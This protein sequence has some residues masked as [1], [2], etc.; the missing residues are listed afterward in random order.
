MAHITVLHLIHHFATAGIGRLVGVW[1]E[2]LEERNLSLH[3]GALSGQ[4]DLK[5]EFRHLGVQVVDFSEN[6]NRSSN[7]IEMVRDYVIANQ[8]SIVHSHSPRTR[9]AAAAALAGL[10]Q[11]AH[12]ATEHLF[13]SPWDRRWGL[14]YALM[15]WFSLYLPDHIVTVS[16]HMRD[17][18]VALPGLSSKRVTAVQNS[19]D[20]EV[21]YMPDERDACRLEFKLAP[22]SKVVGYTGRLEKQ[23]RLDLLLEGFSTVLVQHPQARL[24]IVGDGWLR[25]KLEDLAADLGIS[26]A[27][28]WT[29][30][31]Q[32]I[33]RLLSAMDI[34]IL[35][36]A[37]E[38]LSMS[39]LE[40]MAAG[41]PSIVTDV[42]GA[43]EVVAS[44]S[45]GILIPPGSAS[46]IATA[47]VDLIDHPEKLTALAKAG[48]SR[49]FEDFSVQR[50]AE[51]YE[52]VYQALASKA[53]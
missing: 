48:R 47:I 53:R 49:V 4:G 38:G 52:K 18:V 50:L 30:Y 39:L 21:F 41:K 9:L 51:A 5:E 13:Y 27:V 28:I 16:Q 44:G 19:V 45:T 37:N 26:H 20:C 12:L 23:K 29:G 40:A 36:S 42:G 11:T 33:P 25:P 8:I 43:R 34:F 10:R 1:L 7:S 3:V 32:D 14:F 24:M 15:D 35:P 46:A 22:E 31:R 2:H 17:Q 6:R